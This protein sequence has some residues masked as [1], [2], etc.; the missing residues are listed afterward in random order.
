MKLLKFNLIFLPVLAIILVGVAMISRN[1]LEENAQEHIAQVARLIMETANSSRL[2]T[3]KQ[4]APLLQHKNFKLQAAIAEFQ[5]TI[6]ELPKEVDSSIPKD[7]HYNS[8]K[9]AYL[10]GQQRFLDAQKQLLDS[11]KNK[12][13]DLLDT[14]FHPQS[15]PAFAATE[16]F[17]NLKAQYHD[18]EYKEAT[19]NPTNPEHRSTDWETDIISNFRKNTGQSEYV[20]TRETP[21]G[22]A[23]FL[24]HPL[25]VSNVSC[26]TCHTTP[27]KAPPE[28]IKLYGPAN[29]FGWKLDDIIGAQI[30]TVPMS[31]PVLAADK[32]WGHLTGWLYGA[33]AGIGLA[34][35]LGFALLLW[36]PGS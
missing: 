34:A 8:A 24:A 19:I 1:Y 12:P 21:S 20:G 27:D 11:I 18:Y 36:K 35:N 14:E 3:T 33:F 25:K 30:V 7:V 5:K 31:V 16:I 17:H 15:V 26:L 13:E 23:L 6:S 22:K 29:G 28:M 4:I 10:M 9:R 2:Y 32:A